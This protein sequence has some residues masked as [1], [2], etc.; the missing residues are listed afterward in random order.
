[1]ASCRAYPR[2]IRGHS[3]TGWQMRVRCL[4]IAIPRSGWIG[5]A[6]NRS[7][8]SPNYNF[9]TGDLWVRRPADHEETV[10]QECWAAR[11]RE[12]RIL[13]IASLHA[14]NRSGDPASQFSSATQMPGFVG[15]HRHHSAVPFLSQVRVLRSIVLLCALCGVPPVRIL[16]CRISGRFCLKLA[17]VTGAQTERSDRLP[18]DAQSCG[19][20]RP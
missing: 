14:R 5:L 6:R 9:V 7:D 18:N 11:R 19:A 10:K 8:F 2:I 4:P 17:G 12:N 1:M 13:Q 15:R 3:H 20:V 16:H